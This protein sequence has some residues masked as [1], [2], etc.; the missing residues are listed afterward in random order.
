MW[1]VA[2]GK[3]LLHVEG[4]FHRFPTAIAPDGS[5]VA[6]VRQGENGA[7]QLM[8]FDVASGRER[9]SIPLPQGVS[10]VDD[11]KYRPDGKRLAGFLFAPETSRGP[12]LRDHSG[13]VGRGRRE[14]A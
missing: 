14:T 5:S 12:G 3:E 2:S 10:L 11:L 4:D 6:V 9:R 13:R 1:D 7:A 8:V